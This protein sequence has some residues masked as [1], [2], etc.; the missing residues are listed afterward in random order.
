[1]EEKANEY[2]FKAKLDFG[3]FKLE[4]VKIQLSGHKLNITGKHISS[5][6]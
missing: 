4:E 2:K 6:G 3:G 1:M 5:L